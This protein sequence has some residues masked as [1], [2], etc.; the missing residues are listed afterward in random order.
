MQKIGK[1]NFGSKKIVDSDIDRDRY[2]DRFNT[3]LTIEAFYNFLAV[4]L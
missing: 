3:Y 2:I 4:F 1:V